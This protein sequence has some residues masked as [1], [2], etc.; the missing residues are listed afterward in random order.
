[1]D[2][3]YIY[4]GLCSLLVVFSMLAIFTYAYDVEHVQYSSAQGSIVECD[5]LKA[6][7]TVS[8][9]RVKDLSG[10]ILVGVNLRNADLRQAYLS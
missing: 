4:S 7:N 3:N 10:C 8:S 9:D 6:E 5:K 2:S 1:M